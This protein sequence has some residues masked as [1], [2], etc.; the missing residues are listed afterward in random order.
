M[1]DL[2]TI[3][4][5]IADRSYRVKVPKEEEGKVRSICH[6]VNDK[7]IE[8]KA[9]LATKDT[10]DLLAMALLWVATTSSATNVVDSIDDGKFLKETSEKL[11]G[12]IKKMG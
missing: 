5:L 1:D 4:L 8:Y 10:Q 12:L 9:T 11:D 2:I 3:N 6:A 7:I